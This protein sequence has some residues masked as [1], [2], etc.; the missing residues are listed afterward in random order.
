MESAAA[1]SPDNLAT[2]MHKVGGVQVGFRWLIDTYFRKSNSVDC[3]SYW[4]GWLLTLRNPTTSLVAG[5]QFKL[6]LSRSHIC[7]RKA[8]HKHIPVTGEE[9][10]YR[11]TKPEAEPGFHGP[12]FHVPRAQKRI[13]VGKP[14]RRGG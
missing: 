4:V 12:G 14:R 10:A 9:T 5:L 1:F 8:L 2:I 11:K 13:L 3:L 7:R 6:Q